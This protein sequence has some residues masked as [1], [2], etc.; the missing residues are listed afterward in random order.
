[1][2]LFLL[3]VV[4][5]VVV[6]QEVHWNRQQRGSMVKTNEEECDAWANKMKSRQRPAE[7]DV[8]NVGVFEDLNKRFGGGHSTTA[9]ASSTE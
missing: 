8:A 9:R 2:L 5:G 6:S 7:N 1:M 4:V 3:V